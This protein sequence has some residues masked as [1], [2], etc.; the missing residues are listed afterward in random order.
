MTPTSLETYVRQRYNAVGDNFFPQAEVLMHFYSAQIE[1]ATETMCLRSVYTTTTVAG[2]RIYSFPSK[3]ISIM[4]VEYDGERIFPSDFVDDDSYTGNNP[5]DTGQGKSLYYQQ[6]GDEIYLRPI[7]N[8][9][10]TLKIYSYDIPAE[11]TPTGTLEIP[12]RYHMF[13]ADYALYCMFSKDKNLAMANY[14]YT[15]WEKHKAKAEEV[16]RIRRTGDAFR[17]VK[18]PE[19]LYADLGNIGVWW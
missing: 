1:L 6:W 13:I 10:T 12:S 7:P 9:A 3:T 15:L 16:E 8:E 19:D 17:T 2:Q 14:H 18:D 4:R 5:D 11:V